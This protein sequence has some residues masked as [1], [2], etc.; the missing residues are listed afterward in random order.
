MKK[1]LRIVEIYELHYIENYLP[2]LGINKTMR[3]DCS[4]LRGNCTGLRGDYSGLRGD[5]DMCEITQ[6]D[7]NSSIEIRQLINKEGL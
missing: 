7:R 6:E 1:N 4:G 2:I 5:L 3:G